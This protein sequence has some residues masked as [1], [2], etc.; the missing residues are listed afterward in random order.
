MMADW[1]ELSQ[2][3]ADWMLASSWQLALLVV[4]I[5]LLVRATQLIPVPGVARFRHALWLIVLLKVFLPPSIALP[6]GVGN[7]GISPLVRNHPTASR[8]LQ[9][10]AISQ[11]MVSA[12]APSQAGQPGSTAGR[13]SVTV[14]LMFA[15]A[16]GAALFWFSVVRRHRVLTRAISQ[17]PS[18][19][20]GPIRVA[21]ERA[22]VQ[23]GISRSPDLRVT[24]AM[25]SPFLFGVTQPCVVLPQRFVD[26]ASSSELS[27]VLTHE[28]V[29]LRRCDTWTGWIQVI[30]QGLFWFHPM[31]WWANHHLR[32]AREEVCDD[33]VLRDGGIS[34]ETYGESMMRVLT[35]AK[36]KSIVEGSLVGVFERGTNLQTR[37][38]KIMNHDPSNRP[39]G[40]VSKLAI[41]AIA[42]I[43][44]PMA[45]STVATITA[46]DANGGRK[47][48][49]AKTAYPSIVKTVPAVG[50]TDI[51]TTLKTIRVTFDRDM[52]G[53][54]SWTGGPPLLPPPDKSTKPRWID[55]RTCVLP[56][57]LERGK[58]YRLGINSKSFQNFKS[59]DGTPVP[60]STI[61]FATEGASPEVVAMAQTP[62]I[63]KLVPAN[64]AKNVD[65]KRAKI[66]V[67]FNMPMGAG[68]S[69]TGEQFPHDGGKPSWSKDKRTCTVPVTLKPNQSYQMGLN[70]RSHNNFQSEAGVPLKP[71]RYQFHT[72]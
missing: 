66:S 43:L 13:Q 52:S 70:S 16:A 34:P 14:L 11:A 46:Q 17:Q 10:D 31:V 12:R 56:V 6:S 67:T 40:I 33:S 24:N 9:P 5:A 35:A 4:V 2:G 36:A 41:L 60:P 1:Q 68:M 62:E 30:A 8:L 39:F 64:G 19:D 48:N 71:V 22:A 61:Y 57:S 18:I 32:Q 72:K 3:W 38:E 26:Q 27:A 42:M 69:W 7:W 15:W 50:A 59:A 47:A 58:F 65:S 54:M 51:K 53:G 45:S 55:K 37:L 44:I 25:T 49:R 28:L 29:H 21:F 63:V 23:L 20:E